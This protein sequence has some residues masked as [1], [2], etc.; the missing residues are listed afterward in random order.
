M[1]I[2][3]MLQKHFVDKY[4]QPDF[5]FRPGYRTVISLES[6]LEIIAVLEVVIGLSNECYKKYL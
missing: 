1:Y 6:I 4:H 2:K 5:I 3:L